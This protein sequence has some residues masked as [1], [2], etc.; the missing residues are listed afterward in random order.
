MTI[1]TGWLN[2][3]SVTLVGW[4]RQGGSSDVQAL[5]GPDDATLS[6]VYRIGPSSDWSVYARASYSVSVGASARLVQVMARVVAQYSGQDTGSV[7]NG[8]LV[9]LNEDPTASAF[10]TLYYGS[11]ETV[12]QTWSRSDA[13]AGTYSWSIR[14]RST[15]LLGTIQEH[16]V[17]TLQSRLIYSIPPLAPT[18]LSPTGSI[19]T[20]QPL[21]ETSPNNPANGD[22]VAQ[23]YYEVRRVS[24]DAIMWQSGALNGTSA[25]YGGTALQWGVQYRW[26]AMSVNTYGVSGPWSE[27]VTFTPAANN[28]PTV[29]AVAPSGQ[30]GTTT[31]TISWSYADPDGDAQAAYQ[32]QVRRQSDGVMMWDPG[33]ATGSASAVAYGGSTLAA[34][35]TYEWRV[36]VQ[37]ARGAWSAYTGWTAFTPLTIPNPP[38]LNSPSGLI[39]TLTPT[40]SGSYQQ[41]AGGAE[42]AYQYE[43]RRAGTTIYDSGPV[44]GA[45]ATG[46]AYGT[47]NP[48]DTPSTPPALQWGTA[49]EIRARSRDV[50]NQ[51]SGWSS[52][53]Q[54]ATESPPT[55]PTGLVPTG[56]AVTGQTQPTLQWVHNDPDGDPQGQAEIELAVVGGGY[57]TGYNPKALTQPTT[58]HQVTVALTASPATQYQWRVRTRATAPPGWSPWSGWA[59]FT[60]ATAPSVSVTSPAAN[61]TVTAPALAVQWTMTGGSGTQ[62]TWRV[63]IYDAAEQVIYDTG[64]QS[65]SASSHTLPTGILRNGRQ[66]AVRVDVTDTLA[67]AADSGLIWFSTAWTPP[68]P[69]CPV[70]VTP[71]GDQP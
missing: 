39:R 32:V 69:V 16:R 68:D 56:N 28:P 23:T 5:S 30:I 27:W 47:D 14:V 2:P 41:G 52:W 48:S 6:Y 45:I 67:Q 10:Y 64:T 51:W 13:A 63:R 60:V 3:S 8:G 54:F 36:R 19:G 33:T 21:L 4:Y 18:L 70:V 35:T 34:G 40:I 1:D 44:T 53:V 20:L 46:Q 65:G 31:P 29:A 15:P 17:T 22:P 37:D 66:Y 61:G 57:V 9:Q 71:V 26:R 38:I 58:S 24:D 12:E 50:D 42:A 59:T 7:T 25:T 43:I 11:W 62:A 55:T 49:Y